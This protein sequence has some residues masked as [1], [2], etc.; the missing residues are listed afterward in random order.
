MLV[1]NVAGILTDVLAFLAIIYQLWGLWKE[2]RR[3]HLH[4]EK[5]FVTLLL[6]QVILICEF[7]LDLRRR[8]TMMRP[9]PNQSALELPDLNPLSQNNSVVRPIQSVLDRLQER[10]ID[11]MGERNDLV[12]IDG[13]DQLE[14]EADPETA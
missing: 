3:L 12:G 7:T 8:H 4:T 13:T 11:D 2:K 1:S 9:P 14:G 5:D 6:Q 10:I